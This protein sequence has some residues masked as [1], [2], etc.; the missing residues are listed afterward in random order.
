MQQ[1]FA[2]VELPTFISRFSRALDA[3]DLFEELEDVERTATLL[4]C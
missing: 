1:A 4:R 3:A 2:G